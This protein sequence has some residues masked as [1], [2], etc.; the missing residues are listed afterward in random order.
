MN[1]V[2]GSLEAKCECCDTRKVFVTLSKDGAPGADFICY[3]SAG[4]FLHIHLSETGEATVHAVCSVKCA[5]RLM[6]KLNE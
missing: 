2:Q 6:D 3:G 5:E 1:L 4:F